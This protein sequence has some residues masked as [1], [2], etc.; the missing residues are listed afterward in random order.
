LAEGVKRADLISRLGHLGFPIDGATE[1]CQRL[2]KVA[3]LQKQETDLIMSFRESRISLESV[4][5]HYQR[6]GEFA[7]NNVSLALFEISITFY[8]GAFPHVDVSRDS[9]AYGYKNWTLFEKYVMG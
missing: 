8:L 3:L 7:L 4:F 9:Q 1:L 2:L 5:K 6:L